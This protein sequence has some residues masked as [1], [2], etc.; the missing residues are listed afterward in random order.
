MLFL[1][2]PVNGSG[3]EKRPE[4][5]ENNVIISDKGVAQSAGTI[6]NVV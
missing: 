5:V 6:K 2:Y 1:H 4:L 3:R